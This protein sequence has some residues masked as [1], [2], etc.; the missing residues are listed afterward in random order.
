MCVADSMCVKHCSL[1]SVQRT[2][3]AGVSLIGVK[4]QQGMLLR[5]LG[6]GLFYTL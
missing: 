1:L 6:G 3:L 5:E 2:S 4:Q